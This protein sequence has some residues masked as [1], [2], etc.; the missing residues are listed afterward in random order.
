MMGD[1]TV[2]YIITC[3]FFIEFHYGLY[4]YVYTRYAKTTMCNEH[5]D[6]LILLNSTVSYI[7]SIF[8]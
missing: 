5:R 2:M 4:R 7:D 8:K 3:L 1:P 6:M